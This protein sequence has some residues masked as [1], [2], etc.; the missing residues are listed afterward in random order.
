M[1]L[2]PLAYLREAERLQSMAQRAWVEGDARQAQRCKRLAKRMA[3][4]A[5]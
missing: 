5:R 1:Q 4:F 2:S 3:Q